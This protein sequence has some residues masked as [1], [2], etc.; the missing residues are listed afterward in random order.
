VAQEPAA[1]R[2]VIPLQ[3]ARAVIREDSISIRPAR[4]QLL[5]P[6][7]QAAIAGGTVWVMVTFINALPM[8][9]LVLLLLLA[10]LLGPAAV[11]GFVY[12]VYG[13]EFLVERRKGTAR[14][15]Q[16][17]L[18]LGLGTFELV[19]FDRITRIE[20][21]CDLDEDL[22]SG[23]LQDLVEFD[24]RIVKDNGRVLDVGN[25]TCA[26]AF[27]ED[28]ADRANRLAL[29][30]AEMTGRDL[31]AFELPEGAL[32]LARTP[33]AKRKRAGRRRVARPRPEA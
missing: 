29:A 32:A 1:N 21:H 33:A 19:P 10:I 22:S 2:T 18:G 4:S 23:Q 26:H 15:H 5:T 20:V 28:G 8:W 3:R 30:L 6:L 16:G 11:L 9:V 12:N 13:T 17:F 31:A 25:V 24:V 27:I 7:A 14:W